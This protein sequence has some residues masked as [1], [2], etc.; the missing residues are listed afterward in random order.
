MYAIFSK[1]TFFCLLFLVVFLPS[2][3]L[4]NEYR[5]VGDPI[6]TVYSI[7][8]HQSGN[9]IWWIDQLPDGQ[10]LFAT[11]NGLTTW[12]GENWQRSS[13]PNNSRIRSLTV[14]KD[15]KIYAGAVGELG[16]FVKNTAG[17]FDFNQI[18][19]NHLISDFGQTRSVVSNDD[20]VV[21]STDQCVFVWDGQTIKK[22][23]S[24]QSTGS[25]VFNLNGELLLNDR[26]KFYQVINTNKSPE[27]LEKPWILPAEIRI[28]SLFLNAKK[29]IIM[30][31]S[32][33]GVY[34]LEGNK[35]VQ[36]VTPQSLPINKLY[37][38]L[39]GKDGYYYLNS[40]INGL[41]VL[42]ENFNVLRHYQQNDGIGLATTYAIFEDQQH[43]IWLGG[44]PNISVFQPPHLSSQY[45]SDTGTLDFESIFEING[46]MFFSGTGFYQLTYPDNPLHSPIFKQVPDFDLVVLDM[47][48]VNKQLL[49]GTTEGVYVFDFDPQSDN[50]N[51]TNPS[52]ITTANFVTDIK[53]VPGK[54]I[55]YV[56]IGTHLSRLEKVA[57]VWQ[58]TKLFEDKSGTE[59]LAI[60]AL[61][62][63]EHVVW[64]TTEQQELYRV[65]GITTNGEIASLMSFDNQSAPLGNE[66]VVPFIYRDKLLIGT[67]NG[68]LSYQTNTKNKFE[69]AAFLPASLRTK[70][71]D[72]FRTSEDQ[73]GRLWYHAGRDTGVVY[74]DSNGQLISQEAMFTPY[75][76]S[77]TRGLVYFDEAIWFGVANGKIYRVSQEAISHIPAAA[78]V[79]L[80]YINNI[81]SNEPMPF[82]VDSQQIA[83]KDN[84]IRIGYALSTFSSPRKT[85][86]RTKLTGQGQQKWTEWANESSKDFP[87]LGGGDYTFEIEAKDPWGRMSRAEHLFSVAYP[88]YFS[89]MAW[90][91]YLILSILVIMASIRI[92]QKR[93]NLQLEAQNSALEATV[94][95]RT[96][97]IRQ[98]VGEL[99]QQQILK[100]R[101]FANVSHEFRTPLTLTIGPLETVLQEHSD[102]MEKETKSLTLT[103]LNNA[104]K[105]LALVGQVLDLNRL[106]VGKL[107]LRISEYDVSELLRANQRRF[108]PWAEQHQQNIEC[109]NCE[110][111]HLLFCDLDQLDKCISN[112][113]SNAIKY[114]GDNSHISIELIHTSAKVGIKIADNGLGLSEEAQGQVFERFYQ[115]KSSQNNTSPGS[116]IG[117]ALV[118]EIVNLHHGDIELQANLSE[119]CQFTLWF[120]SGSAHF[121]HEQLI[122]PIILK[123]K[124]NTSA[125]PMDDI[126]LDHARVLVVDDNAE[127]REFICQRLSSTYQ[128]IEAENGE[129]GLISAIRNLPDIIISDVTMPVMSGLELAQ[130]LKANKETSGIPILLLSAQTTKRDIVAGFTSGADDYLI[131]PFD[132]S[133]LV[134]RVNALLNNRRQAAFAIPMLSSELNATTNKLPGF[135]EQLNKHIYQHIHDN[136]LSIEKLAEL[137]FISKETLRRKCNHLHAISPMAYVNQ[138]RIQQA[139]LLLEKH[140][141]DVSEVAYA[142]G[143]NSLAYFSKS[144]KKHYGIS[145]SSLLKVTNI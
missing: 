59:Y 118:K 11:A 116:G 83:Q 114:S 84:S 103:A 111:P 124:E 135:E 51:P 67:Q 117:L 53:V 129:K 108:Q 139:K 42:S 70:N 101:F 120:Q 65:T 2:E 77:G 33:R 141:L 52:L 68:V 143:F 18:K 38:G 72:V 45:P 7:E 94:K 92:G 27:V 66:H 106:E 23:D 28:Q 104:K 16:Y 107:P 91:V 74:A 36:V 82:S 89:K 128:I 142:C 85:Q 49:V 48:V 71:K 20:M 95:T 123:H 86:Y 109:I 10:M 136:D 105:M 87:L 78:N 15:Q 34:R 69:L 55:A 62:N 137:L 60:E 112:L 50:K 35:F 47:I 46:Q 8:E 98:K 6:A 88:W 127:L 102:T 132:T 131:K 41:M 29:Q 63:G 99:K 93:R 31:T 130:K 12:D 119:G 37:G 43:N 125:I 133:E 79:A 97:E 58:E 30:V 5:N 24:Y 140:Q 96:T 121:S 138:L 81:N 64:A 75:N 40:T 32:M 9:Q 145:P 26:N 61:E 115:D 17:K 19:T 21:Y 56:T 57:G 13:T 73:T 110:N 113:L 3:S 144:F 76:Q 25:R 1:I 4:A 90:T 122:E 39:Q 126:E 22:I 54:S 134:M 44:L 80:R 100:D 14:W